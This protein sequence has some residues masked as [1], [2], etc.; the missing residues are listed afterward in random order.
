MQGCSK[1]NQ[2]QVEPPS[3]QFLF[4]F[5]M[6]P[7]QLRIWAGFFKE[8]N[9]YKDSFPQ[10]KNNLAF[11]NKRLKDILSRRPAAGFATLSALYGAKGGKKQRDIPPIR[12]KSG[13]PLKTGPGN[14]RSKTWIFSAR[15]GK[16]NSLPHS[17]ARN[18][19]TL[20]SHGQA[21]CLA[22]FSVFV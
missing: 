16:G 8:G 15:R 12:K 5:D 9:W 20:Q 19:S 1:D 11:W 17:S 13:M 18:S 22:T 4:L 14:Y 6:I 10:F 2:E 21:R 3:F 7:V